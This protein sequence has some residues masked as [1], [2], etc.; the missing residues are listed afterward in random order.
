[1][2]T[3]FCRHCR[4]SIGSLS[5]DMVDTNVLGIEEL[6]EQ[7]RSEMIQ[8]KE[9]GDVHVQTICENCQNAL[10]SNPHYH[11]LDFFIQ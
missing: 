4:N 3:Y 5:H 1:M 11:E 6:S 2:I 10:E 8:H 9:N 7:D